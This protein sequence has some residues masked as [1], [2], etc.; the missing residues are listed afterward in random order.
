MTVTK[1]FITVG[2]RRVHYTRTGRGPAVSLLHA[3]PC[4]AKVLRMPQE[5]FAGSFTAFAFDTPGF[6]LSD[7]LPLEQPEIEDF[8][9]GLAEAL[10]AMGVEQ[11][12]T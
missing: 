5:V 7:L 2:N 9:D 4:S 1:H 12:A 10:S 3:S 8:A 11:S 6:G